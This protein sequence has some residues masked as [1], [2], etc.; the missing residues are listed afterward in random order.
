[1]GFGGGF[2]SAALTNATQDAAAQKAG[3]NEGNA[4]KLTGLNAQ[5]QLLRQQREDDNKKALQDA[6]IKN[7]AS[8]DIMRKA[9]ADALT[10]PRPAAPP[11]TLKP[12]EALRQDDGSYKVEVPA[13]PSAPIVGT[14][15]YNA[16]RASQPMTPY[17]RA[18][19]AQR[20]AGAG[21][22]G[23]KVSGDERK[24]SALYENAQ[25]ANNIL[26]NTKQPTLR[27]KAASM[28]PVAGNYLMSPEYQR[29][30]QAAYQLSEAW[31][32][33]T[34]GAAISESEI[35]RNAQNYFAQPGEDDKTVAQKIR[36]REQIVR[37]LK[38]M[39]GR[40]A[41]PTAPASIEAN[42][43]RYSVPYEP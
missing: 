42:P 14:P 21:S 12:G 43:D 37:S 36:S 17:E 38:K 13:K 33:A 23:V 22:A 9:Q 41:D 25:A 34:S 31:L 15:E 28:V 40:A 10:H 16:A 1:M 11:Q 24:N 20:A 19:L 30:A 2:L 4:T 35:R 27:D 32:R 26:R 18:S 3:E 5:L 7:F 6:Q 8:E 39:A 29:T